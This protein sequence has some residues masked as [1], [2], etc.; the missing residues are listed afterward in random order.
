MK[1]RERNICLV[2]FST[3]QSGW[4]R[5]DGCMQYIVS[6]LYGQSVLLGGYAV[7]TAHSAPTARETIED[8]L[9]QLINATMYINTYNEL[10]LICHNVFLKY[11]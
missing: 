7:R 4:F 10:P 1:L 3:I 5:V 9:S 8:M 2:F 11:G 6:D